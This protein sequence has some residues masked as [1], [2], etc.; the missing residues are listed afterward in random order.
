MVQAMSTIRDLPMEVWSRI[1]TFLPFADLLHTFWALEHARVLPDT[2]TNASNAFLQFCSGVVEE[3]EQELRREEQVRRV[4]R[5]SL[6]L[7]TLLIEMGFDATR[8]E[9]AIELCGGRED[10][11]FE[12]LLHRY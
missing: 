4:H 11:I 9:L 6:R 8:I 12:Y 7:H 10:A 3:R 1:A 5:I 2:C